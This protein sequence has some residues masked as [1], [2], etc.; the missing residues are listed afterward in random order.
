MHIGSFGL[1]LIFSLLLFQAHAVSQK[2]ITAGSYGASDFNGTIKIGAPISFQLGDAYFTYGNTIA[3]SWNMFV[4]WVL[5]RGGIDLNG[6]RYAVSIHYI[7][8]FSDEDHVLDICD[9]LTNPAHQVDFMFGPYSSGL[10]E[11]CRMTTEQRGV[12]L[13]T[14]GTSVTEIFLGTELMFGTLPGDYQY[15]K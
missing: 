7:E 15:A 13:M 11:S 6:L 5:D 10:T 9:Y 4:E 1:Y 12:L 14:G 2:S 8:D 3:N